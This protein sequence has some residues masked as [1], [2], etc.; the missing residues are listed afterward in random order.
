MRHV[1]AREKVGGVLD[2]YEGTKNVYFCPSTCYSPSP[3]PRKGPKTRSNPPPPAAAS[4]PQLGISRD[5]PL[6]THKQHHFIGLTEGI[7]KASFD[8]QSGG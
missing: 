4:L 1:R 8:H 5:S 3:P 7:Q 6:R 2:V